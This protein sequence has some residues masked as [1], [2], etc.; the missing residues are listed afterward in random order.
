MSFVKLANRLGLRAGRRGELTRVLVFPYLV[1][2]LVSD[3]GGDAPVANARH[4]FG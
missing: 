2:G 3:G 1:S 4:E